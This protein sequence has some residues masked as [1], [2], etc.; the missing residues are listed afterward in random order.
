MKNRFLRLIILIFIVSVVFYFNG[1]SEKLLQ[2]QTVEAFGDLI[3]DFHVPLGDPIFSLF[4]M[5]P[6]DNEGR[7]V[8][9]TNNGTVSRFVA[10]KGFRTGGLG[11]DPKIETELD[12]VIKEGS[13]IKFG[14]Q[15]LSDFFA[16]SSTTNGVLLDIFSPTD[17]K[18]YVFDVTFPT[19]A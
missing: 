12:L 2:S 16:A 1:V 19:S 4:N 18:T 6:G 10:V 14:P 5:K 17:H 9:V 11:D 13:N 8:D 15:K 7:N 3:V